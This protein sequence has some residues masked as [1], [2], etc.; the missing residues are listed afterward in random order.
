MKNKVHLWTFKDA[1][2]VLLS[3]HDTLGPNMAVLRDRFPM[4]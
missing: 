3:T 2:R 4:V 1:W